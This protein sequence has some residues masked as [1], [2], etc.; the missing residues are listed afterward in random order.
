MKHPHRWFAS[1]VAAV[2]TF[3]TTPA[4]EAGH[5]HRYGHCGSS[6]TVRYHHPVS[7]YRHTPYG[8]DSRRVYTQP[9]YRPHHH[10]YVH[11][12]SRPVYHYNRYCPPRPVICPPQP[13]YPV[14]RHSGLYIGGSWR[15]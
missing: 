12:H 2:A 11:P 7:S 6:V 8:C 3:M 9:V 15:L 13:C 14:I 5:P 1:A 4:A 10:H